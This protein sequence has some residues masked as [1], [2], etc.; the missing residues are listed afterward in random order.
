[1][2]LFTRYRDHATYKA[3]EHAKV[4]NG[5][6]LTAAHVTL[7]IVDYTLVASDS[8]GREGFNLHD[9]TSPGITRIGSRSVLTLHTRRG[10]RAYDVT[11]ANPLTIAR[12]VSH[13]QSVSL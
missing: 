13:L 6:L 2:S 3:E 10:N 9:I 7:E 12:F 1:M 5:T 8:T 4:T 11:G